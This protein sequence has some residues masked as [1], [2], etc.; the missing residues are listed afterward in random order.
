MRT[1]LHDIA[2][3]FT[4]SLFAVLFTTLGIMGVAYASTNGGLFGEVLNNILASGNW[5]SPGDGTVKN[6]DK[7]GGFSASN[8]AKLQPYTCPPN[9]CVNGFTNTGMIICK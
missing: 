9:T 7:L 4:F 5:E 3:A 8:F 6:A 2:R 1:L